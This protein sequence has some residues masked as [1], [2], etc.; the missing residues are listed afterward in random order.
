MLADRIPLAVELGGRIPFLVELGQST[1]RGGIRVWPI[2]Y[3]AFGAPRVELGCEP[4]CCTRGGCEGGVGQSNPLA[5]ELSQSNPLA[6]RAW[7]I[8]F[9]FRL[10]EAWSIK[11]RCWFELGDSNP[12]G[13]WPIKSCRAWDAAGGAKVRAALLYQRWA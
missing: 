11:P 9:R 7:P 1:P 10:T 6:S 5:A 3:A 2:N 12:L 8:N 4:H 13:G